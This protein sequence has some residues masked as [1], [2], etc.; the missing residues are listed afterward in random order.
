MPK[1][2]SPEGWLECVPEDPAKSYL[3]E[4]KARFLASV[5]LL[6]RLFGQA[7]SPRPQPLGDR[8][9]GPATGG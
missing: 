4:A 9:P 6:E 2:F 7:A 1:S 8:P 3:A 5:N